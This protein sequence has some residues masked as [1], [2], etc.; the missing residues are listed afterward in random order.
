MSAL[1]SAGILNEGQWDDRVLQVMLANYR[2]TGQNGLREDALS[3]LNLEK[4]GW[5]YYHNQLNMSIAP[6]PSAQL[7]AMNLVIYKTTGYQPLLDRTKLALKLLMQAYPDK[8]RFYNGMQQDRARMLL[9][10]AW[11]VRVD[12]TPEH[13]EWLTFMTK[14]FIKHQDSSGAIFEELGTGKGTFPDQKS[15]ETYGISETSLIQENGDPVS[16]LLYTLNSGF[17]SLH[18]VVA[19][20]CDPEFIKAEDKLAQFLCRIQTSSDALP[21]LDGTWFR[22][23]DFDRWEYWGSN[24]DSGWGAWCVETG[25]IQGSLL[26]TFALR[27]M[28]TNLW[29]LMVKRPLNIHLEKN[30][31]QLL[32]DK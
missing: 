13:R 20:T 30:I 9:P 22:S 3:S 4:N 12:D 11:L 15:N 19:V 1:T 18:E 31:K 17:A 24:G 5:E 32:T 8:W 7:L 23:F 16:D 26:T 14:E 27:Q 29:D 28:D 2:T 6:F 25:W 21:E 10:L